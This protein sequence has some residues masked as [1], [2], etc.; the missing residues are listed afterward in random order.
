MKPIRAALALMG[1]AV[2]G[3]CDVPTEAPIIDQR[4]ILPVENTS[5]SVNELLPAG[6]TASGNAFLLSVDPFSTSAALQDL[7]SACSAFQGLTAPAPAFE[8]TLT[9]SQ[10]LPSDVTGANISSASVQVAVTN[11]FNF[12]PINGGGSISIT[13]QDGVGGRP[14]ADVV[15]TGTLPPS[16]TV[17]RT[18]NVDPGSVGTTVFATVVVTSPGGELTTIDGT[19]RLDVNATPGTIAASSA[20]VDVSGQA[21]T[22][23]PVDLDVEDID[24]SISDRIQNGSIVLA[25]TNPFGVALTAQADIEYP[26]GTLSKPLSVGAGATSTTTLS[27]TGSELRSFLG[28]NSVRFTGTGTVSSTAGVI[29]VTPG[30][31]AVIEATLDVNLQ[32]GN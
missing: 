9:L 24:S 6:V 10:D 22:I 1:L 15:I 30:Q 25:I 23:D 7:C 29:T 11:H 26:G 4:W 8:G 2:L 27:Y 17:T 21:V 19:Q 14:L 28:K 3:A 12:D 18:L 20:S 31:E 32:I 13:L 5:I 16:A